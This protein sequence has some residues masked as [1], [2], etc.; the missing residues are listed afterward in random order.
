MNKKLSLV[1]FISLL[2]PLT[3]CNQYVQGTILFELDGGTFVD[4]TFNTTSLIGEAGTRINIQIPD[5]YKEGYYFVGWREKDSA[6]NYREI[7]PKIDEETGEY[8]YLYPYGTDTLYAYFEPLEEIKF[9]LTDATSRNGKLIAPK[10]NEDDSFS[11]N[12]LSGYANK[13]IPSE[14]YLPTASGDSLYFSYWYTDYPLVEKENEETHQVHYY[15]DDTQPIGK[16]PFVEQFTGGMVFPIVDDDQELVLKAAWEEYPKITIHFNI[17]N[18][19]NH[20]F[21][22][23]RNASISNELIDLM[24]TT[25]DL[26]ITA[27]KDEYLLISGDETYR[28]DG[29]YL[30]EELTKQFGLNSSLSVS[31]IDLYLKWSNQIEVTL[32]YAGGTFNN[33]SS[34]TILSFAGDVLGEEYD[35]VKPVKNNADFVGFYLNDEMFDFSNQPLPST[36][37]TLIAEYDD[38]PILT[39]MYDYPDD[40]MGEKL[41]SQSLVQKPHSDISAFLSN[42]REQNEDSTL[43]IGEL[44]YLVDGVQHSFTSN[45]MPDENMTI[46]LPLLYKP[47]VHMVTC[48]GDNGN[49]VEGEIADTYLEAKSSS[50]VDKQYSLTLESEFSC[51]DESYTITT[52]YYYDGVIYLFDGLYSSADFSSLI[53]LP[54]TLELSSTTRNEVTIY[55]KMTKA[56]KLSFF[57]RDGEDLTALNKSLNILPGKYVGDY[58]EELQTLLGDFDHLE[59]KVGDDYVVVSSLLP[60]VDSEIV[61]VY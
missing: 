35:D 61:V 57:S 5:A 58:E 24:Q 38:Y 1:L 54:Y 7:T 21:Q 28:F 52:D 50:D 23:E 2:A 43:E 36:D 11:G 40:Y 3:A 47:L 26:D 10:I 49:Y 32:D 46:Y 14:A 34:Q 17:E 42:C 16:Y 20:T 39:L 59:I 9:D 60:S 22:A 15:I 55:R 37:V 12:T 27:D 25:F 6:G 45:I 48:Y 18:L 30:D 56:I 44:Y 13:E 53:T 33:Q 4:P 31:D 19:E 8:Y 29:F 51:Q 41:N